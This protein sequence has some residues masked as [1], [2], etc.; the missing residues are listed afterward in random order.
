MITAIKRD[1]KP[2]KGDTKK[3]A[4]AVHAKTPVVLQAPIDLP[5]QEDAEL[6]M[7]LS[8]LSPEEVADLANRALAS[9][10]RLQR[11]TYERLTQNGS[12]LLVEFRQQLLLSQIR[13]TRSRA[14]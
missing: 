3:L 7:S 1:F 9:A 4:R 14:A 5:S 6:L 11:D 2:T 8:Q 10:T 13:S 12:Q